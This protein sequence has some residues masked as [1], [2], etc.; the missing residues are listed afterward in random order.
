MG[1]I[2]N[3]KL[4]RKRKARDEAAKAADARRAGHGRTKAERETEAVRR[5]LAERALDASRLDDQ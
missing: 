1:E 4:A 5:A 3:L 2:V